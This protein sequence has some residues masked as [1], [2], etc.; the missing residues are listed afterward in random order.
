MVRVE[1]NQLIS[2]YQWRGDGCLPTKQPIAI[3]DSRMNVVEGYI[4]GVVTPGFSQV[5]IMLDNAAGRRFPRGSPD[6]PVLCIPVLLLLTSLH[7]HR[8]SRPRYQEPPKSLHF[9]ETLTEIVVYVRVNEKQE[10]LHS[11]LWQISQEVRSL[12]RW[13]R[14]RPTNLQKEMKAKVRH[15]LKEWLAISRPSDCCEMVHLWAIA[16]VSTWA[17]L[18]QIVFTTSGPV[19]G[20]VWLGS[21]G[22]FGTSN[23]VGCMPAVGQLFAGLASDCKRS[24]RHMWFA[25]WVVSW[26]GC[27]TDKASEKKASPSLDAL[28]LPVCGLPTSLHVHVTTGAHLAQSHLHWSPAAHECNSWHACPGGTAGTCTRSPSVPLYSSPLVV[29]YHVL[30]ISHH[31]NFIY[32]HLAPSVVILSLRRCPSLH[33]TLPDYRISARGGWLPNGLSFRSQ[34]EQLRSKITAD[35]QASITQLHIDTKPS[36]KQLQMTL[37]SELQKGQEQLQNKF[38]KLNGSVTGLPS[39]FIEKLGNVTTKLQR[40]IDDTRSELGIIKE[41]CAIQANKSKEFMISLEERPNCGAIM[42]EVNLHFES[43][44]GSFNRHLV[45][46]LQNMEKAHHLEQTKDR[47]RNS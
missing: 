10:R 35:F 30:V 19:M 41:N 15:M 39:E 46:K 7:P 8:L 17:M 47:G 13:R 36:Q 43:Q 25:T 32:R 2:Q 45:V 21:G 3:G 37:T 14:E 34:G 42:E 9:T 6:S 44:L 1:G 11:H 4:P 23:G 5:G 38:E 33:H 24:M 26:N 12:E 18:G 40:E 20:R 28:P 22:H 16:V 31:I 29:G 27:L